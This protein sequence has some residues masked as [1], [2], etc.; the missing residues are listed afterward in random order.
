[1]S[2]AAG[3][4]S[5]WRRFAVGGRSKN[6]DGVSG[7]RVDRAGGI[8]RDGGC[9]GGEARDRVRGRGAVGDAGRIDQDLVEWGRGG[10]TGGDVEIARGVE[11][12]GGVCGLYGDG[13]RVGWR[14]IALPVCR[15]L[16][17]AAALARGA[18]L[19]HVDG[20]CFVGG[21]GYVVATSDRQQEH[22]GRTEGKKVF[23]C[24]EIFLGTDWEMHAV[25]YI[26]QRVVFDRKLN[27]LNGWNGNRANSSPQPEALIPLER[28]LCLAAGKLVGDFC[29]TKY[30]GSI[31]HVLDR[32]S[33]VRIWVWFWT[34]D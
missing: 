17:H 13:E 23:E 32:T 3:D 22:G 20:G 25:A 30:H 33:P 21:Y 19:G 5:R 4:V 7:E 11:G 34:E 8:D 18:I 2:E 31:E 29:P 10:A 28:S 15:E 1:M 24:H 14:D 16:E 27:C 12:K 6:A 26:D 9:R